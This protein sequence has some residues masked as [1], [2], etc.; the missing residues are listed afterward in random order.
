MNDSNS[1]NS[2]SWE[3]THYRDNKNAQADCKILSQSLRR[4]H[5][6]VFWVV[7]RQNSYEFRA[8]K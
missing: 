3:I 2:D 7:T 8:E 6:T 4:P 1:W 5:D